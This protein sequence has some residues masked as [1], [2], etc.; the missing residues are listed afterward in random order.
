MAVTH[1]EMIVR[2]LAAIVLGGLIGVERGRRDHP[3]GLRT[4]ALVA[5]ASAAFMVVSSQFVFFQNYVAGGL[6][7][8]DT[9]RI[10]AGVV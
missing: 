3:A 7:H 8:V 2:M 5:L 4:H 1:G 9:S 10:A 6:V